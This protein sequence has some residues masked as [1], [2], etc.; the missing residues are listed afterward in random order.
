MKQDG[1]I[2]KSVMGSEHNSKS[3]QMAVDG[4]RVNKQNI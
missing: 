4:P 1:K 2:K 3:L